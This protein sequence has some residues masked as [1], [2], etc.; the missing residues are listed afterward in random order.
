MFTHSVTCVLLAAL[1]LGGDLAASAQ[2]TPPDSQQIQAIFRSGAEAM[3][4]GD[5]AAAED[6]FR[7]A[8][9]L[10]PG[11][12]EA[13]LDL[14]LAQLRNGKLTDAMASM[15]RALQIDPSAHGAHLF[16]GI[17][18]YQTNHIDDA[19]ANLQKAAEEDTGNPQAFMWLG[20]VDLSTDHP[21]Q[22]TSALDRAS[23]LA[24]NDLNILDYRVQAHMAVARESYTRIYQLDA[25]SWRLHR[26]NAQIDAQ[27]R[28]HPQ[29]IQEYQAAIRIAP[30]QAD[31][32]E[33]LGWEYRQTGQLDLAERAFQQQLQLT[34]GNPIAMYNLAST[35]VDGGQ[36]EQALPLLEQ[37]VKLYGRP[38]VA[39]YYLGRAYAA[40]TKNQLAAAEFEKAITLGGETQ[41][42]S[43][44]A[45]GQ[46]YNQ[47]GRAADARAAVV[48]FQQLQNAAA[49]ERAKGI[50][51][52]RK[53]NAGAEARPD[54]PSTQ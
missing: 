7:R 31:L 25:G 33:G 38:T 3:H 48:K 50:E 17:A 47:M 8:T 41:R 43:L 40:Q 26:L 46:V 22:A 44:Y 24:P 23:E 53:L 20:I 39:D 45:L 27:A 52:W 19:M 14:G 32:Y 34:P 15:Q 51:D 35:E 28:Q 16:L 54:G 18:E 6:E 29:A 36:T 37:V 9:V 11:M 21:D 30:K 42:R 49:Q 10:A 4:R 12:A 1:G 13:W 2:E 5:A